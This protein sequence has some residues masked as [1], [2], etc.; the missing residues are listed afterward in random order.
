MRITPEVD[1]MI[2]KTMVSQQ[3]VEG[4]QQFVCDML[5]N[6]EFRHVESPADLERILGS[7]GASNER[8]RTNRRSMIV[9]AIALPSATCD[10]LARKPEPTRADRCY[11]L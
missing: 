8:A 2:A 1:V 3:R 6:E 4:P 9:A 5:E 10:D 7:G 11:R